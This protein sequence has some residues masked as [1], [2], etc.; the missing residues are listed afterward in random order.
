MVY[1]PLDPLARDVVG[2]R[3]LTTI[4]ERT[5]SRVAIYEGE[6]TAMKTHLTTGLNHRVTRRAGFGLAATAVVAGLAPAARGEG[7]D[8]RGYGTESDYA[9][10]SYVEDNMDT[11]GYIAAVSA[12]FN[13]GS[14][15]SAVF[16]PYGDLLEIRVGKKNYGV[17]VEVKVYHSADASGAPY[18]LLDT[19]TFLGFDREQVFNLG[20]PDG[21]GN[22]KEGRW[23]AI[24]MDA[25][26]F[27]GWSS[28]A[29]GKA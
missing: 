12:T 25:E 15:Q 1:E 7:R 11:G 17:R 8:E 6:T 16:E 10:Q 29:Y 20:T 27:G 21:A 13:D 3:E 28:W 4:R 5:E 18:G 24:R 14:V 9:C 22:I 2:Y 26:G 23:V 19:D